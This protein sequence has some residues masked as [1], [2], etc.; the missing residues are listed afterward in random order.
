MYGELLNEVV[1]FIIGCFE[2]DTPTYL[3]FHNITHTKHTVEHATEIARFYHLDEKNTFI[4]LVA[5]WFHDIG[6]LYTSPGDH[7][8]KSAEMMEAFLKSKCPAETVESIQSAI[9][10]TKYGVAPNSLVERIICDADTY[11][12]G[13][14]YFF[15]TDTLVEKEIELRTGSTSAQWEE[16]SLNLLKAHQF[17]T[18]YCKDL[19]DEGKKK[20][21][22]ILESWG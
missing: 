8:A 11:H 5:A 9:Y 12:F 7:E 15:T 16:H 4:L 20:N 1:A 2:S 22:S 14:T 21:I 17:Y 19:L 3:A 10:A 18:A 6:Y 13:T